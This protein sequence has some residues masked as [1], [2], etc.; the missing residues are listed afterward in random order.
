MKGTRTQSERSGG[1]TRS[2]SNAGAVLT[3]NP[4]PAEGLVYVNVNGDENVNENEN[5]NE[6]VN[7]NVNGDVNG[8]D[9]NRGRSWS[10]PAS[11]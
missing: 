8:D 5:E 6:N 9:R 3:R 7:E 4:E 11:P 10:W 1:G 2:R